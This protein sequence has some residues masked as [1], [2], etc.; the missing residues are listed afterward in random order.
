MA[1]RD[2]PT[3]TY[4]ALVIAV[5]DASSWVSLW[6]EEAQANSCPPTLVALVAG[7]HSRRAVAHRTRR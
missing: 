7:T 2:K 6:P 3:S 5:I 4:G 1:R